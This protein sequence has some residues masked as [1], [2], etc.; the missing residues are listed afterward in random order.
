MFVVEILWQRIHLAAHDS[1]LEMMSRVYF[2]SPA[3]PSVL[4][5]LHYIQGS[6]EDVDQAT[7]D[8]HTTVVYTSSPLRILHLG[9]RSSACPLV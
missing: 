1:G 2:S 9:L 4:S 7:W 8:V 6:Q 5:Q 3:A